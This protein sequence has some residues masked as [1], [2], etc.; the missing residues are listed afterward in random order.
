MKN[1]K[2]TKVSIKFITILGLILIVLTTIYVINKTQKSIE[3]ADLQTKENKEIEIAK[4]TESKSDEKIPTSRS[5]T[6]RK[7]AS[8]Q[9]QSTENKE[10]QT[11]KE[12]TETAKQ[13]ASN[14]TKYTPINQVKISKSMDLTT[15]TGL[16]REDFIKLIAGVKVDTAGFFKENAGTIYDKCE[17]YQ[18]NEIFFCGLISAESGWNIAGN[19][20]RTHNYI[21]LMSGGKLIQFPSVD[22]G[23]EAAAKTLHNN[24]LTPGGKLYHGKT[25]QGVKTRFCPASSTWVDLVYGRMSQII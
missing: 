24:Y 14:T 25:L 16:S 23:L 17:K 8:K 9:K 12:V 22:A 18:I 6:S 10:I 13:L 11:Q 15:R 21:S 1:N 5:T 20:R 2:D 4:T 7:T 3:L 19:H